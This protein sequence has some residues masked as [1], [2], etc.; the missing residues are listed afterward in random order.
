MFFFFS[1]AFP[2][3]WW[4]YCSGLFS[5]EQQ[6]SK[7]CVRAEDAGQEHVPA[8]CR[9]RAGDGGLDQHPQ[10][11]LTQQLWDRHAGEEE[12]RRSRWSVWSPVST[13]Y[14]KKPMAQKQYTLLFRHLLTSS[15]V[16]FTSFILWTW[17]LRFF[18]Y[19]TTHRLNTHLVSVC[20]C[21]KSTTNLPDS[22][23]Y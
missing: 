1:S 10:Q 6:G 17:S 8:G 9:Q 15:P 23:F 22:H 21:K 19:R 13:Y 16:S 14:L 7:V 3:H 12:R 2:C 11:D 20:L 18:R 4:S 5:A